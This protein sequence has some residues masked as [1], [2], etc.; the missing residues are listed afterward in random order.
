MSDEQLSARRG[1]SDDPDIVVNCDSMGQC[2]RVISDWMLAGV[3]SK[4]LWVVRADSDDQSAYTA[5]LLMWV[6]FDDE[7]LVW[8]AE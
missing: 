6:R 4:Y 3:S 1:N 5:T 7:W 2:L 8:L